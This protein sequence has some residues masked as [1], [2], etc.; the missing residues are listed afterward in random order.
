MDE[1]NQFWEVIN[2]HLTVQTVQTLTWLNVDMSDW[3][4]MGNTPNVSRMFSACMWWPDTSSLS[5]TLLFIMTYK[6]HGGMQITCW[7]WYI[8]NVNFPPVWLGQLGVNQNHVKDYVK[9]LTMS[10]LFYCMEILP[11]TVH[12]VLESKSSPQICFLNMHRSL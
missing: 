4:H 5:N 12:A 8:A 11:G 2:T 6:F 1:M 3:V 9:Y 7:E 10:V